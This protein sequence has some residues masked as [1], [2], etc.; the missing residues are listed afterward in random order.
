MYSLWECQLFEG[1]KI[2]TYINFDP[3]EWKHRYACPHTAHWTHSPQW[4]SQL[5][6]DLAI[7]GANVQGI[8]M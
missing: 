8:S 2:V 4:R 7:I 6:D 5:E 3:V 1:I